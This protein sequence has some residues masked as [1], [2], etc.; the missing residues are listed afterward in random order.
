[1]GKKKSL[2]DAALA[3]AEMGYAVFPC[4]PGSKKP[5]TANGF[6]DAVTDLETIEKFWTQHPTANIGIPTQGLLV[7]DFDPVDGESNPWLS[8]DPDKLLDLSLGERQMTPRG[9]SHY[10]FKQPVGKNWRSTASKLA[11]KIDT[12]CD[13]GY[14]VAAPSMVGG[15]AYRWAEGMGLDKCSYEDLAEPANWMIY[16]LDQL[17]TG[18]GSS[19]KTT[20][21]KKGNA[22][23]KGQRN[24]ALTSMAG[25]MRRVGMSESEV[26]SALLT[27][28]MERCSPPMKPK[29]VE[30]IAWS[31]CRYEPD[32]I[33]VAVTENHY[34]QL[35]DKEEEERIVQEDDGEDIVDPGPIPERLLSVPGLINKIRDYTLETAPYPD[36]ALAFTSALSC[37]GFLGGRKI[38]DEYDNRTNNY[39]ISLANSGVGK[40]HPRN[41]VQKILFEVGYT[42]CLSDDF[43]SGAG[44]EDRLLATPNVLFQTDEIDGLLNAMNKGRDP[45]F[46]EIM[47]VLMKMN[48]SANSIYPM[49][50]KAGRD[51][52]YINQPSLSLFGTAIP[53]HFY[54]AI[55][56]KMMTNGFFAR[57]LVTEAGKR[58]KYSNAKTKAIPQDII[59]EVRWWKD[60]RPEG[61]NLASLN[62]VPKVVMLTEEANEAMSTFCKY[63][64]DQYAK[65]EARGDIATMTIWARA[66]EKARRLCLCYAISVDRVNPVITLEATMWAME[67]VDHQTKRMIFMASRYLS[68]SDFDNKCRKVIDF[69]TEQRKKFGDKWVTYRSISRKFRW[70]CRDHE[71]IRDSLKAQG[72][73]ETDFIPTKRRPC[74][75]YRLL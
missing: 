39:L 70:K 24:S 43:A 18:D 29:E 58:G 2:L 60:F 50:V 63:A 5:F 21:I 9:G 56:E 46:E 69:L 61:G 62:P 59:D 12:R 27:A 65:A 20:E 16:R 66:S 19:K 37:M 4:L 30:K 34:D 52:A 11:D 67:F 49:R 72:L 47:K 51:N 48:T 35:C 22:I 74:A 68:G 54:G 7:V 33:A 41:V 13:G 31:V 32:Q 53:L 23:P 8:D 1:M 64:D 25:S 17:A 10:V 40:N 55:S 38:R 3:Y 28:N 6:K 44:I 45:R 26:L 14:I 15:K 57:I 73:I 36:L 71:E 75:V 42:N